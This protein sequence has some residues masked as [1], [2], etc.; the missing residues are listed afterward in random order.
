MRCRVFEDGLD[1]YPGHLF[2]MHPLSR[3]PYSVFMKKILQEIG[4]AIELPN[5][6]DADVPS[7]PEW[8]HIFPAG[9][10]FAADGRGPWVLDDPEAVIAASRREKV[11]MYVDRDHEDVFASRGT[12]IEAAGWVEEIEAR[13]DG[14]WARVEWTNHATYQ[15]QNKLYRYISPVFEV[16]R[17]SGKV[18]KINNISLTNNPALELTALARR[19]AASTQTKE[20]DMDFVKQIA[21]A[22]GLP[23]DADEKTVLTA[24]AALAAGKEGRDTEA[25]A[26][27]KALDLGEDAKQDE[28]IAALGTVKETASRKTETGDADPDP[29]KYV[30]MAQH[31]EVA[32]Q[33]KKLQED[34][35]KGKA[36]TAVEAAMKEG[37]ITP[38]NKEWA[39]SYAQKDPEGFASFIKDA[40]VVVA[41]GSQISGKNPPAGDGALTNTEMQVA[42]ML[43]TPR[44]KLEEAKKKQTAT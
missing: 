41:A 20:D 2:P 5:W 26:V 42:S 8:V 35:A 39:M 17:E 14:L 21:K 37:K 12:R 29:S 40:P 13:E 27:R 32:S 34:T 11:K 38:A 18:L 36:E 10:S 33:L 23:E 43:G 22:L 16:E 7:V 6:S 44:D 4:Q 3:H 28:V 1:R 9:E 15:I 25:A 24:A 19:Q 30:T 31:Q